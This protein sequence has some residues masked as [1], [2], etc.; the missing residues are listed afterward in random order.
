M[1]RMAAEQ[2]AAGNGAV[3]EHT[4]CLLSAGRSL[5]CRVHNRFKSHRSNLLLLSRNA[6]VE[7]QADEVASFVG[8]DSAL[9]SYH[10]CC[11]M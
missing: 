10:H 2:K 9:Q 6:R 7:Q 1:K 8:A 5:P 4:C 3:T 11:N